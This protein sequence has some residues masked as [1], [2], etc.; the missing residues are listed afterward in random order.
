MDHQTISVTYCRALALNLTPRGNQILGVGLM[1]TE[2]DECVGIFHAIYHRVVQ[3]QADAVSDTWLDKAKLPFMVVAGQN[4][5]LDD[6]FCRVAQRQRE[7]VREV[8]SD[9]ERGSCTK[10]HHTAVCHT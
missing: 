2:D 4:S 8:D 3:M 1:I 6:M 5:A 7:V 10:T 9:A